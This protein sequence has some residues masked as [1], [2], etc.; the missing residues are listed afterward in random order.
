LNV[1]VLL[2]PALHVRRGMARAASRT[3]ADEEL[4]TPG[5]LTPTAAS[6]SVCHGSDRETVHAGDRRPQ[7]PAG[8]GGNDSS[9][10]NPRDS[11]SW[12]TIFFRP[13]DPGRH[14]PRRIHPA[15]TSR[16]LQPGPDRR[17]DRPQS[18]L[19]CRPVQPAC[20]TSPGPLRHNATA[21]TLRVAM[22]TAVARNGSDRSHDGGRRQGRQEPLPGRSWP[23]SSS[24]AQLAGGPYRRLR[25]L[26][27]KRCGAN[28]DV[29]AGPGPIND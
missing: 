19:R 20:S 28:Q 1:R 16:H 29:A 21:H 25:W 9:W 14:G 10:T 2:Q 26:N 7:A 11:L 13:V 17:E 5:W 6:R 4:G 18:L 3:N 15:G 8:R 27:S 23:F 24:S 22:S 12:P